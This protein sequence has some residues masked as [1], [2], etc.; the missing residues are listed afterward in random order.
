MFASASHPVPATTNPLGAKG[1]GEAGCAGALPSVMNALIDALSPYGIRHLD[2]PATQRAVWQAIQAARV[3]SS[4]GWVECTAKPITSSAPMS[5]PGWCAG[6]QLFRPVVPARR[7]RAQAKTL[8]L[9]KR[10][11]GRPI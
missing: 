3:N 5:A 9:Y 1:C 2:M 6:S 8:D 4:V 7:F 10:P 11:A